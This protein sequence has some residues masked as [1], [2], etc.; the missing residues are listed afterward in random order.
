MTLGTTLYVSK[1]EEAIALYRDA[2][3]LSL[4][5]NAKNADGTYLHAELQRDG[6]TIIAVSESD[7]SAIRDAMLKSPMP[8]VSLGV[9]LDTDDELRHAFDALSAGGHVIRPLGPMPWTPLSADLVDRFGVCWYIFV[10]QHT[11]D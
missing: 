1:G 3:G 6:Q 9:N 5:Y 11:P 7:E 10:S 8:T 4:G 2:F